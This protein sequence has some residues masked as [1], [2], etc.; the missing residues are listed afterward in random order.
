MAGGVYMCVQRG[1]EGDRQTDRSCRTLPDSFET[2][3]RMRTS[4]VAWDVTG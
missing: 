3:F 4:R 2:A 1:R